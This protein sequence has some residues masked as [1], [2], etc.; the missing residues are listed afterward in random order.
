M[1]D[2]GNVY[3]YLMSGDNPVSFFRADIDDFLD[4]NPSFRWIELVPDL[5]VGKVTDPHKAGIVSI[6]LSIHD[7]TKNGPINFEQF[8]AWKK[9]PPKRLEVVKVKAYIF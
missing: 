1:Y 6:K 3:I 9:P 7:K 2:I 5:S 8:D 4:P